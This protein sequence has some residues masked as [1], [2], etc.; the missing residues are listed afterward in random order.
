MADPGRP[1][2]RRRLLATLAVL[3]PLLLRPLL[4]LL[5]AS[6]RLEIVGAE[7]L[8][9]SWARGERAILCCW[10]NR[11]L[12]LPVVAAGEPVC[13]LVSQHRDGDLATGLLGAWGI[14]TVRGS[15]TRG[16]VAGSLRLIDAYHHGH[17]LAVL[18]DGPRGPR[19]AAKPGVIRLART[20]GAPIYP[21]AY[22]ASR[23]WQLSSWDRLVI[24]APF[25]RVAI[26]VGA[27]LT[28]PARPSAEEVE[29]LRGELEGRLAA[30]T[31]AAETRVGVAAPAVDSATVAPPPA[32]DRLPPP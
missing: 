12:M 3:A 24:P 20:V 23:A 9:A 16:A 6:L 22:A 26:L 25:A 28:V 31:A 32:P 17:N 5:R 15:T 4:R 14:A 29:A 8:R 1:T 21:M 30:V 18:P 11:L 13:I 2:L 19:Y 10:H 27:P 7:A